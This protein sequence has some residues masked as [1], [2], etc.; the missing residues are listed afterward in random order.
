[1]DVKTPSG[2][3]ASSA[4]RVVATF[5]VSTVWKGQVTQT[6]TITTPGSSASCG[7][8]FEQGKQYVVYGR[9]F[10]GVVSAILCSRTRLA[11][12]ASE[13]LAALGAGQQPAAGQQSPAQL[14]ATGEGGAAGGTE[15]LIA[16]AGLLTVLA[17]AVLN[18]LIRQRR[19]NANREA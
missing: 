11:A 9:A 14:P 10:E 16:T 8:T 7:I 3:I 13:D 2:P 5:E 18:G 19:V 4:D 1:M 15:I 6:F 17:G 12:D